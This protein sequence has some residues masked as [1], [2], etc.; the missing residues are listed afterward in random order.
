MSD[1]SQL[2]LWLSECV[3]CVTNT[4]MDRQT[5]TFIYTASHP[6]PA[7]W[8]FHLWLNEFV[9]GMVCQTHRWTHRHPH[10]FILIHVITSWLSLWLVSMLKVWQTYRWTDRHP[11]LFLL[12]H[13]RH[14]PAESVIEWACGWC[15][16]ESRCFYSQFK[17]DGNFLRLTLLCQ[18]RL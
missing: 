6:L 8:V 14:Q 12:I 5:P 10:L 18:P 7:S 3:D 13:V 2:S 11:L 1:T 16:L 15:W 9:D 17:M 4:Q